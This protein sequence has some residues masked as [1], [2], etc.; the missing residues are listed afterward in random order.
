VSD[1]IPS[2]HSTGN[3]LRDVHDR[4]NQRLRVDAAVTANIAVAEVQ[5]DA[6]S[7]DNIAISDGTDTLEINSDGS[8]NVNVAD[9]TLSHVND[10]VAIGDGTNLVGVT[11]DNALKVDASGTIQPVSQSTSPWV[12]SG[13]INTI[14]VVGTLDAFARQRISEPYTLG[15]YKHLYG[16]DPNFVDNIVNGGSIV[17]QPN[18]ACARLTTSSNSNSKV[19]HQTKYYHHYMPGKSQ[20]VMSS[21]N[22]YASVPNVTKRTGLFDDQNGIF[23]EQVGD[24]TLNIVLRSYVN[25]IVQ[26]NRVPRSLWTADKCDG[27]GTSGFNLDITKTQLVFIDFQWLGVGRVRVGFSHEGKFIEAHQFDGENNLTTVY[28][29]NP[30]LPVRCEI[31]NT[32]TTA[33]SY[34]DQ[35]CSTVVSEGGYVEAGLDWALANPSLRTLGIGQTLPI[36]AIRLK[37]TYK[38]YLNRMIVRLG[39][40]EVFTDSGNVQFSIVKL[41]NASSLTGG[42][43]VWTSSATDSGVEYLADATG[44][45]NADTMSVGYA[46]SASNG[47][48]KAGSNSAATTPSSAK[49]NYIVQNFD[50]TDSEVYAIIVKNIDVKATNVGVG[51]QWRE[52]Y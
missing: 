29:S 25:G 41:P 43:G 50:S 17:F 7:G 1:F 34:M 31:L 2:K 24:G 39:Q 4:V 15:D 3:V 51:L 11:E 44:Y 19:T 26:E 20:L 27:T 38:T 40:T 30:N 37:N 14:P 32:G 47:G 9:I 16:L 52:V 28:M 12:V 35:I 36:L 10:S 49:K 42:A 33:G 45:S 18:K 48:S 22:F 13:T 8:I 6:E 5:I 23:F 21:F 46:A